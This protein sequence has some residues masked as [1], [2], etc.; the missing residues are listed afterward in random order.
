MRL[1]VLLSIMLGISTLV[2]CGGGKGGAAYPGL[3]VPLTAEEEAGLIYVREEEEL[4]RDLY[5]TI[6]NNKGLIS[7][8]NISLNSES[9]HA[10]T[11]LDL[12]NTYG[13]ADP[14]TGQPDTYSS[15]ELQTLYNQLL[16]DATGPAST[17]LSA[18]MVGALV[19]EVDIFDITQMKVLVQPEHAAIIA[20]YDNLLC[21]S[22]NHLRAFV[23]QIEALTVTTYT[24]QFLPAAEVQAILVSPK[25]MCMM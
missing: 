17:D 24:P 6:F 7:F 20:A 25:E 21:G 16:A 8:Q 5:M 4:A 19:E 1:F 23:P 22:R 11:M 3:G 15:P 18:L 10:Q 2:A 14:S 9:K 12:L 13:V